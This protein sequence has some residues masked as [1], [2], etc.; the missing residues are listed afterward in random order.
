MQLLLSDADMSQL[1][2]I[3]LP[4]CGALSPYFLLFNSLMDCHGEF[5]G[6][7][8]PFIPLSDFMLPASVF[9]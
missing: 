2:R 9:P 5:V 6:M 8:K 7:I 4:G 3:C 1:E